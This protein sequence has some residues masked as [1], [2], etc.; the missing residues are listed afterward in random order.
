MNT[1]RLGVLI[2]GRGSNLQAL[3]DACASPGYPAHIGLVLSNKADA[4]GLERAKSSG[5]QT[6]VVEHKK[7]ADRESFEKALTVVLEEAKIELVCLAGFMRILTPY[8]VEQW[9]DRVVNIHP[10]LLPSFK[11]V[12]T[13]ERALSA[14][15]KVHGCSVHY[16]R[17]EMDG[18]PIIGQAAIPVLANDDFATLG[19]RV[20]K[21]EHALYPACVR[22]I[23]EGRVRLVDEICHVDG[24]ID[25]Q[26][27]IVNPKS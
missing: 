22:A 4:L 1:K 11:G 21:A 3:I 16:V 13:H 19:A 25:V 17:P 18:G 24:E 23:C 10:S 6:A 9:R 8:F 5:I 14:G 27:M 26:T 7:F 12:D 20:L 15:V 2:S